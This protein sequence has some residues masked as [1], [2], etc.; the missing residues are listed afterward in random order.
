[1]KTEIRIQILA[2]EAATDA[3]IVEVCELIVPQMV[4]E[5][6]IWRAIY[7]R[8]GEQIGHVAIEVRA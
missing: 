4:I 6:D 8:E 1:M 5:G 7:S 2:D 3:A